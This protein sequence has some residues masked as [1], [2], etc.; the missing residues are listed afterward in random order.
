MLNTIVYQGT[1][2]TIQFYFS[3]MIFIKTIHQIWKIILFW[4]SVQSN[5][6]LGSKPR[7]FAMILHVC[8]IFYCSPSYANVWGGVWIPKSIPCIEDAYSQVSM[9]QAGWNKHT[10]RGKAW[11]VNK[12]AGSNKRSGW[13]KNLNLK[14]PGSITIFQSHQMEEKFTKNFW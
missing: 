2:C 11:K 13:G 1:W 5:S 7:A 9:K 12:R 8:Q 14:H 4:P 10:G 3:F 6:T